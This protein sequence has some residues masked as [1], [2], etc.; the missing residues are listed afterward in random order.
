[1][2]LVFELQRFVGVKRE[3]REHDWWFWEQVVLCLSFVEE[4]ED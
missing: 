1:M 4:W 2:G 3:K